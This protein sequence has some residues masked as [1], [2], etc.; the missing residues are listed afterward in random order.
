MSS[1]S[2]RILCDL[3][4]EQFKNKH[5]EIPE[6]YLPHTKFSDRTASGLTSCIISWIRLCGYQ[7]ERINVTGRQI[8]Q[9]QTY[10]D[11]L[12]HQRQIGSL[13]WIPTTGTRGSADISATI[14]GRSV[15]IEVKVGRD[16][17]RP[18][19]KE[20]QKSIEEAG[21]LYFIARD[22]QQFYEWYIETF[23]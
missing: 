5:P 22:F 21:G 11:V 10:T 23:E 1:N 7:S 3:S 19:Q 12:G 17:Q 6:S 9:R 13:K 15:K 14:Q 2:L 18:D 20:Y 8:D 16:R 4:W